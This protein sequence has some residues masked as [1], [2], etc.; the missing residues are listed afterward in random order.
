MYH[1]SNP[2]NQS[3]CHPQHGCCHC[4]VLHYCHGYLNVCGICGGRGYT[5]NYDNLPPGAYFLMPITYTC[6][7]CNG[8]GKISGINPGF[9]PGYIPI[10]ITTTGTNYE[11]ITP[12]TITTNPSP[13]NT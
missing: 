2:N 1:K 7:A 5:S 10:T 3:C 6:Y 8:T 11:G 13:L 4:H 9:I 12:Y